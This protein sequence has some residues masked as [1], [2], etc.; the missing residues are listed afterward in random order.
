[1]RHTKSILCAICLFVSSLSC[2]GSDLTIFS[3]VSNK[4]ESAP[5]DTI[6]N[7]IQARIIPISITDG[8][9]SKAV[10]KYQN[11][12]DSIQK[13][14]NKE[15][16]YAIIGSGTFGSAAATIWASESRPKFLVLISGVGINGSEIAKRLFTSSTFFIDPE[17]SSSVRKD[18][19]AEISRGKTGG[20]IPADFKE[21]LS[22]QPYQYLRRITCPTFC[23]F[24]TA[25]AIAE[26]YANSM[27]VEE[28]LPLSAKNLI[29]VYPRTG[30]CLRISDNDSNIPFIGDKK[31]QASRLNARAIA[32]VVSWITGNLEWVESYCSRS[33]LYPKLLDVNVNR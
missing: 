28:S 31:P 8:S 25:D 3:F 15:D 6:T 22:Y 27:S 12:L 20:I 17:F 14:S 10:A 7:K 30:Y 18:I 11:M 33:R 1:M 26:W 13:T 21:L 5:S 19:L 9:I 16:S 23:A 32:D 2:L 24:G 4:Y 29:R